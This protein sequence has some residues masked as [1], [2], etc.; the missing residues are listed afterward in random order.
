MPRRSA[1]S[2]LAARA[3]QA[4]FDA[5]IAAMRPMRRARGRR[6]GRA[7][8]GGPLERASRD[9]PAAWKSR[10][11][12]ALSR[13]RRRRSLSPCPDTLL[14]LEAR[15]RPRQP[16]QSSRPR[17]DQLK[18]QALKIAMEDRRADAGDLARG[19]RG[20]GAATPPPRPAPTRLSRARLETDHRRSTSHSELTTRATPTSIAGVT[21]SSRN[22]QPH[23]TPSA[24]M[25]S[26][27]VNVRDG[28]M[29][30]SRVKKAR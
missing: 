1:L 20:A 18:M 2:E 7:R 16:Q 11:G 23:S 21:A 15:V 14:N 3:S 12:S 6:R 26:P 25:M 13:R 28:P 29:S 22:S 27:V 4:R 19:H 17:G 9:L 5:L 24:G 10:R 30:R 8:P